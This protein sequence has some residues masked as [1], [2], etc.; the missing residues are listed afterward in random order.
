MYR[1]GDDT[2]RAPADL[3]NAKAV[4]KQ[5][6]NT[7]SARSLIKRPITNWPVAR[8][9]TPTYSSVRRYKMGS[10]RD[11]IR[12]NKYAAKQMPLTLQKEPKRLPDEADQLEISSVQKYPSEFSKNSEY[13]RGRAEDQHINRYFIRNNFRRLPARRTYNRQL[14][15]QYR[16]RTIRGRQFRRW[17]PQIQHLLRTEVQQRRPVEQKQPF[18][19][20]VEFENEV[21]DNQARMIKANIPGERVVQQGSV[22]VTPDQDTTDNR[23]P[24][25]LRRRLFSQPNHQII[26]EDIGLAPKASLVPQATQKLGIAQSLEHEN[27]YKEQLNKNIRQV[28]YRRKMPLPANHSY[29]F[30]DYRF[31]DRYY[32]QRKQENIPLRD[33]YL[34]RSK[35]VDDTKSDKLFERQLNRQYA[36]SKKTVDHKK[37]VGRLVKFDPPREYRRTYVRR[38][39]AG[40]QRKSFHAIP[41]YNEKYNLRRQQDIGSMVMLPNHSY[42][43]RL[44][45]RRKQ[46][47]MK[48][49]RRIFPRRLDPV[50]RQL[51]KQ[52]LMQERLMARD[53][54]IAVKSDKPATTRDHLPGEKWKHYLMQEKLMARDK[55]IAA[56]LD[57]PATTRDHLP[58]EK[59]KHY[60]MQERLMARDKLIAAKSDKPATTR[61]HLPGEKWKHYLMQER[62]MARDKLIAAKSDKPATTRDHLPGEKWKQHLMQERLMARDKLIAAN[63][64][65]P[66]TTRDHLP[67]EK[68]K[69]YLM[70]ERLMVRDKLIAAKSDKPA[71]TRDHLPGEKWKQHLM[72]ERLMARDKL[73][74]GNSDKPATTRDHLPGEKWKHYLMQERL[75]ARDKLIAAKSDKPAT[76]R[77]HLPGEKWKHYLMQERL[78]AR[79]KLIAAKSDKPA[80]TRDHLPGE[81]YSKNQLLERDKFLPNRRHNKSARAGSKLGSSLT[82]KDQNQDAPTWLIHGPQQ[83]MPLPHTPDIRR[84][85][86]VGSQ[87]VVRV[88]DGTRRFGLMLPE[89]LQNGQSDYA[90][91]WQDVLGMSNRDL[92]AEAGS[93]AAPDGPQVNNKDPGIHLE[94]QLNLDNQKGMLYVVIA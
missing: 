82:D 76:T 57:K 90:S 93:Q 87:P 81:K 27:I 46:Y 92:L 15:E 39:L 32:D 41:D 3:D 42:K 36:S 51:R 14:F 38:P 4:E 11:F 10:N 16:R 2:I 74:A 80:T 75:M 6:E 50:N 52:Y 64:D 69:H 22:K 70:Q 24:Y 55:L 20:K 45:I 48:P 62:L 40:K 35:L 34:N 37:I 33:M 43:P 53:K 29:K 9:R 21:G 83:R 73:I 17:R 84:T 13:K 63:S 94:H 23:S 56:K 59:W 8:Q 19:K 30:R 88:G 5:T 58:G 89:M 54:L 66:A 44:N 67:G 72:Q 25:V 77:D 47:N 85:P 86:S 12:M 91:E 26:D 68:W 78:M 28:A 79:D 65:K 71:T 31:F 18:A 1:K 61:D 60:L 7:D 49:S